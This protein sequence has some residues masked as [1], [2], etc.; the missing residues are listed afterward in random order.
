MERFVEACPRCLDERRWLAEQMEAL[1]PEEFELACH[2]CQQMANAL[3]RGLD[4]VMVEIERTK[5]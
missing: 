4:G 1:S 3:W 5:H 2:A